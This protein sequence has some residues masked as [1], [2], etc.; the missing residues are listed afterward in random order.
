MIFYYKNALEM[1]FYYKNPLEMI[2]Y[3]TML[4][5]WCIY[6]NSYEMKKK[7]HWNDFAMKLH[8]ELFSL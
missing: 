8:W 4:W 7:M 1:I 2:F 5:K 6:E 3:Y